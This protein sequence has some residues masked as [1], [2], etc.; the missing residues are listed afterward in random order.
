MC[1]DKKTTY[2]VLVF[3]CG[4]EIGLEIA[5]SFKFDKHFE[6]IGVSSIADHGKFIYEN[7]IQIASSIQDKQCLHELKEI[8]DTHGCDLVYPTMDLVAHVLKS[9]EQYLGIPVVCSP[10]ETSSICVSKRKTYA[11]LYGKIPTPIV[12][13]SIE[14]INDFP[15]FVK[16]DVGYGSRGVKKISN[17]HELKQFISENHEKEVVMLEF[18]PGKEYTI[19]CFTNIHNELLFAGGR[20]R[21]R[22]SNGISVSSESSAEITDKFLPLARAINNTLKL[23]GAWFFQLK[24]DQNG[25][26]KLLEVACRLA[27]SSSVHRSK[28]INFAALSCYTALNRD[29][30]IVAQKFNVKIDR[31][32][33]RK[34]Q[35]DFK[36]DN[37]YVDLDDT[38]IVNTKV[39]HE[40]ISF[41]YACRNKEI[42]LILITKH[43]GNLTKT[44]QDYAIESMWDEVIHLNMDQ[45]KSDF[46]HYGS[47]IF[48][49]DSFQERQEV[50]INKGIPVFSVDAIPHFSP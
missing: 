31:A 8:I 24:E 22:I 17:E 34:V 20:E 11:S 14:E 1:V 15:V 41:L 42:K 32:L 47:S 5:E 37:V 10:I 7:Y 4:S 44:L 35:L 46:I 48:I 6:L 50:S 40:L 28:G 36:F 49:D 2:K 12:Y 38:V 9:Q 13:N 39:N 19:D 33:S 25:N 29:V 16:P 23:R 3:P 26:V 30:E 21:G 43:R 18:L 27:G 45:R